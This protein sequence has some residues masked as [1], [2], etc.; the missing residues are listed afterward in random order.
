[1]KNLI[2]SSS[3]L[4]RGALPLVALFGFAAAPAYSA[5][6]HPAT[7][8]YATIQPNAANT[9]YVYTFSWVAPDTDN[10]AW[11][12]TYSDTRRSQPYG[13]NNGNIDDVNTGSAGG[14]FVGPGSQSVRYA[15]GMSGTP[16]N[17]E[18]SPANTASI[19]QWQDPMD[20]TVGAIAP[21]VANPR[22]DCTGNWT[23]VENF[24][25]G[26]GIQGVTGVFS[27]N[28]NGTGAVTGNGV[29]FSVDTD[30]FAG[31]L[32][33][34]DDFSPMLVGYSHIN[35]SNPPNPYPNTGYVRVEVP[36]P[37]QY[38]T[39]TVGATTKQ[40][41]T[42]TLNNVSTTA[43]GGGI[44]DVVVT[45]AGQSWSPK[46]VAVTVGN[47]ANRAAQTVAIRDA[48]IADADIGSV[49]T[50]FFTVTSTT[51]TVVLTAKNFAANDTTMNVGLF[52][53][54][55]I[56]TGPVAAAFSANTA[57]GALSVTA[58][59]AVV[60]VTGALIVGSPLAVNVALAANETSASAATKIRTALSIAPITN[61]YTVGGTGTEVI[62]TRNVVAAPNVW[63]ATLNI[64]IAN[65]TSGGVTVAPTSEGADAFTTR[66]F[67]GTYTENAAIELTVTTTP[68]GTY[69]AKIAVSGDM[70]SD[71]NVDADDLTA[72]AAGYGGWAAAASYSGIDGAGKWYATG[73][74][75]AD[76]DTDNKDLGYVIGAFAAAPYTLPTATGSATLTYDPLTGN[77]KL[78]ATTAGGAKITS[79][80]LQT[81]AATIIPANYNTVTGGTYNGTY[82]NVTTSVIGDTDTSLA[83][84]T[85]SAIDLG[86]VFPTGMDLTQL[87]AYLT[88]RVYTGESGTRQQQLTLA[89][90]SA[91]TLDHFAISAIASPQTVGTAITGITL[92]AQDAANATFTGFTGT[93]TF[94]GTAGI[95][96]TS[97]SF[98]NGVLSGVSVTPT[99]A[100]SNLT[101]TVTDPVSG[102]TGSATIATVQTRYAAWSGGALANVDTNND[103]VLN[104]VAWVVGAASPS[105]TATALLPVSDLT[106]DPDFLTFT[107]RRT[108]KANTDSKTAIAVEYGSDLSGWTTAVHDGTNIIITPADDGAGVGIDLVQVKI[109]K[110]L[111]V[112]SSLFARLKVVIT[113]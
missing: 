56:T 54:T 7:S 38:E 24:S 5:G 16:V 88:T 12:T 98:V 110:T 41:E 50:G 29:G 100:G 22:F 25:L 90:A 72:A 73:N 94:G 49:A 80:Q 47:N 68:E 109:K 75:D 36:F 61:F 37:P 52:P 92:R 111:A 43:A 34:T 97:A 67:P 87:T 89:V 39:A 6:T 31:L 99:V 113:P 9:G 57:L 84:V 20:Y 76:T 40:V 63:D 81:S 53:N 66:F 44:L 58:G 64:A 105:A 60:T 10:D 62:L 46:T 86:N 8:A 3:A 21:S 77:V 103:G 19:V 74:V 30:T 65:G 71:G 101:F 33:H 48:L 93:V 18:F 104:G 35:N 42:L 107:Y 83:G 108:D 106:T 112:G 13:A 1:M 4:L 96:G 82:K 27:T 17:T 78:N 51:S 15:W 11:G 91:A 45:A 79:F 59:D 70:D 23:N 26:S 95:T 32:E 55:A 69:N 28:P 2:P 102:K 14:N 85:G